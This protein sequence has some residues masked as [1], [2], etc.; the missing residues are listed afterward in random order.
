MLYN[1]HHVAN[2]PIPTLSLVLRVVV[3]VFI[4]STFY[5]LS[6]TFTHAQEGLTF[7]V[8][9]PLFQVNLDP[10]TTWSSTIRV[11]NGNPYGMT[12]YADPV[13]FEPEGEEGRP[14]IILT[15]NAF[16]GDTPQGLASWIQ[17]PQVALNVGGEQTYEIPITIEVPD[18]ASPGGHYA[19]VLIGNRAPQT[20][21]E[22]GTVNV[23]SSIA[24]LIFLTV[25]G[26][27]DERGRI[28]D[29]VTEKSLYEIP[30]ARFSLRF[31]NQ[32]NVHLQ[33]QGN[34]T[35][36]NM[37]GKERGQV[38][39]NQGKHFGNVLPG[40]IRKF[41]FVW[42]ADSGEWD[43]GKYK[44]VATLGYGKDAKQFAT[45][46]NY[47]WVLPVWKMLQLGLGVLALL[48]FL[49]WGI[50]AYVRKALAL[51]TARLGYPEP[52]VTTTTSPSSVEQNMQQTVLQQKEE[53][54]KPVFELQTLIRPIEAGIVDL[55]NA[56]TRTPVPPT[57][58]PK[59]PAR[60]SIAEQVAQLHKDETQ[61]DSL[62]SF[63]KTYRFFFLFIAVVAF[64]IVVASALLSD[65]LTYESSFE[66]QIEQAD[67]T[68]RPVE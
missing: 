32:G 27:V 23:A 44:A 29:F 6:S 55:K 34:I 35:I 48:A 26:D 42:S 62:G 65:V 19:A 14:R 28:R 24:S 47:F 31:E 20:T 10:G 3:G 30:E 21:V 60:P 59:Q 57:I 39:L 56:A 40:S 51:E 2:V 54:P 11:V 16:E 67:G 49:W 37:F 61:V 8:T 5:V 38:V 41:S 7:T 12:I 45:A 9:P 53:A 68:Y 63:L 64:S 4:L 25:S 36:Y 17:V 33:P 43:I 1:S 22:G 50:R 66:V 13:S 52:S 15:E 58:E 18:D 46:T